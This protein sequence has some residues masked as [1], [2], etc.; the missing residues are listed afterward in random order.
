LE[1]KVLNFSVA[2]LSAHLNTVVERLEKLA[3]LN[4]IEATNKQTNK[5]ANKQTNK[6][7]LFV[8]YVTMLL[9]KK[10]TDVYIQIRLW[11]SLL[12]APWC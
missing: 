7:R 12:C 11:S 9:D 6:Q 8:N 10:L 5:Q 3:N 4:L 1:T 2:Q